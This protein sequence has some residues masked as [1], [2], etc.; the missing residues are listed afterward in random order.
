MPRALCLVK[1]RVGQS[2]AVA[3]CSDATDEAKREEG[4]SC[5]LGWPPSTAPPAAGHD[6]LPQFAK[7]LRRAESSG[8]HGR[9]FV[10]AA[11]L[12][13]PRFG[14]LVPHLQQC[15]VAPRCSGAVMPTWASTTS[16]RLCL[17]KCAFQKMCTVSECTTS[18]S[19]AP[20]E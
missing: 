5:S 18:L 1:N 8:W 15:H 11:W 2:E 3:R 13:A 12:L 10:L 17:W 4:Y 14:T 9:K 16:S 6:G 19:L 20:S 7:T